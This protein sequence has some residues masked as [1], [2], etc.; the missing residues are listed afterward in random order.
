MTS[1]AMIAEQ[2]AAALKGRRIGGVWMAPCPAHQDRTPSLSIACA[3]GGKI[4]VHCFAGCSQ[5]AV[6]DQL[7]RDGLWPSTPQQ[8]QDRAPE[9]VGAAAR[10]W[11]GN[12]APNRRALSIWDAA[13]LASGTLAE[14]YLRS[15]GLTCPAPKTLRFHPQLKHPTGSLW[16][17]M[18][19]LVTRGVDNEPV[20]IH[21]TY[22][23]HDGTGKAPIDPAKMMLGPCSGGAVRLASATDLVM[24]GEG[25]ET[26]LAAMQLT[27]HPAW[28]ALSTT[29][30]WALELPAAI[31]K[32]IVL[33]DGDAP[34]EA[35]A[36]ACAHRL[37][38]GGRRV[39]I[40]RASRGMDFNDVLLAQH[41]LE[42]AR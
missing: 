9:P 29:G 25:I 17:C 14:A 11:T 28:A 30:L 36:S 2:L 42:K 39:S 31:R 33:A 8:P 6:I 34:G 4:L 16:P 21:R 24:V 37:S 32:V 38:R 26:C 5:A 10:N 22:L 3:P 23:K 19:A 7:T 35:A 1:S 41:R 20:A 15:R 12:A 13:S 18:V 27:G 40:D